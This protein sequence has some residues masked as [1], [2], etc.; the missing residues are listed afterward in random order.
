MKKSRSILVFLLVILIVSLIPF[1]SYAKQSGY[2]IR[3]KN[4]KYVE[5]HLA[6]GK[7][8]KDKTVKV[9]KNTY[10]IAKGKVVKINGKDIGT[11][12]TKAKKTV[13]INKGKTYNGIYGGKVYKNGLVNTKANGFV[14]IGKVKYLCTKGKLFT[15]IYK[16]KYY[17]KN[18]LYQKTYIGF[19]KYNKKTYL[20]GKGILYT[21]L[22]YNKYYTNGR[23][24]T[25][26]N[27]FKT[28]NGSK[29]YFI[30]GV[31]SDPT[32]ANPL[33]IL[34]VGNSYTYYNGYPQMLSK[35]IAKTKKSAIVVRAT[36]GSLSLQDLMT[37]NQISYAAF[38]NGTVIAEGSNTTLS[39]VL[40]KDFG[41]LK[42]AGKWDYIIS[43]N[44]GSTSTI[45][46]G[47]VNFYNM[48]KGNIASS[49]RYIIHGMYYA[50]S[51]S[52]SRYNEHLK[53]SQQCKCS[54]INSNAYYSIYKANFN[55]KW[56]EDL[57]IQDSSYHPSG[58]GGYLLALCIY[59]RIFGTNSFARSET[60]NVFIPLYNAAGGTTKEFAPNKFNA[61]S[62]STAFSMSVE[63]AE[64]KKLQAFVRNYSDVYIGVPLY[65]QDYVL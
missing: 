39:E 56:V 2:F 18:G 6:N 46:S 52:T 47:D 29:Y 28:I 21:G 31:V 30:K 37:S 65:I 32:V 63:L 44:N 9:G 25:K 24:N 33:K 5:Y 23:V 54:I 58:R 59:A 60:D 40:K 16:N 41:N 34:L 4:N 48:I 26:M 1:T 57:T 12:K 10:K 19:I 36:K 27:G 7:L 8:V 11:V 15:G 64:A 38:K 50:A 42:R 20:I 51:T 3:S 45:V 17:Y 49:S 55:S 22:Y 14:K 53:A 13:L 35:M 43:Q 62:S 61:K